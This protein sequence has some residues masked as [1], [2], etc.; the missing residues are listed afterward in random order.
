MLIP[1]SFGSNCRR[2]SEK[3]TQDDFTVNFTT[4]R[5]DSRLHVIIMPPTGGMNFIDRS[6]GRQFCH[7]G[8]N[9]YILE[10]WTGDDEY[11]IDYTIH[12]RLYA[13]AQRAIQLIVDSIPEGDSVG[14]LGTSVGALFTAQAIGSKPRLQTGFSIVGGAH[15][16]EI[17]VTSAQ[18]AME[19]AKEVRRKE[20]HFSSDEE[21]LKE[22]DPF[23]KID[24]FY[25]DGHKGKTLG[26]VHSPLDIVV[27]AKNQ[28]LLMDIWKP[29]KII[30]INHNHMWSIVEAWLLN[31]K[32]I[33]D[34]FKSSLVSKLQP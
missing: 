21:Y 23:I 8:M 32:E 24:P 6:Y 31:Q 20:F 28:R 10:N 22:L 16:A 29:E 7:D 4:Y 14:I 15:I 30:T 26:V 2:D 33:S 9:S 25:M 3:I 13:R 27:P 12:N 17:I 11:V 34:F 5:T 1:F 18:G 19:K